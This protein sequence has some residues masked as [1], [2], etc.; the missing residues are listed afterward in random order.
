[1]F[2]VYELDEF[3]NF[4]KFCQCPFLY[5]TL[6]EGQSL[7]RSLTQRKEGL[8]SPQAFSTSGLK[9]YHRR[10]KFWPLYQ[11][12]LKTNAKCQTRS[13]TRRIQNLSKKIFHNSLQ[14][15]LK[16]LFSGTR[17]ESFSLDIIICQT[18]RSF[19]IDWLDNFWWSV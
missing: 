13:S 14:L 5:R 12:L 6:V 11:S 16:N 19:Y 10:R 3:D 15:V 17:F 18:S 9:I 2:I 7:T 1:M 8:R 4:I